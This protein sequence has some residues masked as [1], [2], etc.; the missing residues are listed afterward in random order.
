MPANTPGP[1]MVT[2]I[3]AQISELIERDDTIMNSATGRTSATLGVVLR[4]A[5]YARGIARTTE[6]A[7]PSVAMLMV[8]QSGRPRFATKRQSGGTIRIARSAACVG[9]S[10]TKAQIVFSEISCQQ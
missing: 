4:A 6:I 7:V 9:A 8:S 5:Q 1:M 2:S 10:V 3:R